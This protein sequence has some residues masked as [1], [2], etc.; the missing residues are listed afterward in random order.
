MRKILEINLYINNVKIA[1]CGSIIL[2]PYATSTARKFLFHNLKFKTTEDFL[3]LN[4]IQVRISCRSKYSNV[5]PI[6]EF[7][8]LL[9]DFDSK[10]KWVY[11]LVHHDYEEYRQGVIDVL[12]SWQKGEKIDWFSLPTKGLLK[13][14]YITA[15]LHYSGV[16]TEI[17]DKDLYKIDMSLVREYRDVLYLMGEAFFGERGYMGHSFH[18]FVDCLRCIFH[19]GGFAES[20]KIIFENTERLVIEDDTLFF[21]DLKKEL[22]I[23]GISILKG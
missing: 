14:D 23:H 21:E 9:L 22:I 2:E 18:T 4:K 16:S 15:C 12:A 10:L 20:K 19:K 1:K 11:G 17:I 7:N 8:I 13:E 3:S 5:K 6:Y